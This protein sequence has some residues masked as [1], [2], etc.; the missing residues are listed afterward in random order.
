VVQILTEVQ[1]RVAQ[2][3]IDAPPLN[4]LTAALQ[5]ELRRALVELRA[6]TDHNAV[7]ISSAVPGVFSAGADVREHIG[8]E[9]CA[10]MLKSAH[11]LIA[12]LLRCPV[13]TLCCVQGSC[14][15]GAFELAL[16]CDQ[17]LALDDARFGTPEIQLG[18][19]PP[20]ALVLMP[21]KL[22]AL[23]ASELIQGGQTVTAREFSRRGGARLAQGEPA[24]AIA[25]AARVYASLPRGPLVE[26]TRL[27]R[28]GAAE[29]F[30]AQVGGIERD[31]LERLLSLYDANEGPEAFLAKRKP[32]WDHTQAG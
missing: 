3:R 14:L 32:D 16:A 29:R 2:L 23:L 17:I 20:A 25:Q 8:R 31:Y 22:P 28:D 12:E 19:Y 30:L 1:N 24:D 26:A 9:N 10:A 27:L 7:L 4:I 13:P 15:G 11:A 5:D 6:R 21:A 18:C